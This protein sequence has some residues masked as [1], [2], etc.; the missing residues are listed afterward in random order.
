MTVILPTSRN[1][2]VNIVE[3]FKNW[4]GFFMI[5]YSGRGHKDT[6]G[7]QESLTIVSYILNLFISKIFIWGLV[8]QIQH[9]LFREVVKIVCYLSIIG[10]STA[11]VDS[12]AAVVAICAVAFATHSSMESGGALATGG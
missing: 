12:I 10:A 6:I 1:Q 4:I 2:V 3:D 8:K 11:L 9:G 7:W 5:L